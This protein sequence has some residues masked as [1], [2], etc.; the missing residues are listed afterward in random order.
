ML[1]QLCCNAKEASFLQKPE[2][3][4]KKKKL[5]NCLRLLASDI[6]L[7]KKKLHKK[8]QQKLQQK[9]QPKKKKAFNGIYMTDRRIYSYNGQDDDDN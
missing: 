9:L 5:S 4:W 2:C 7:I 6:E 8:L 3:L 1:V